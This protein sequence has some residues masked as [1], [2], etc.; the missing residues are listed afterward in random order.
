MRL[1]TGFLVIG[2][3]IAGSPI[4][5]RALLMLTE[6]RNHL[7]GTTSVERV[8]FVLYDQL[9]L[10]AFQRAFAQMKD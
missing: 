10:A 2:S 3:G 6:V 1:V 7:H 8:E 5:S 9:A 4:Y